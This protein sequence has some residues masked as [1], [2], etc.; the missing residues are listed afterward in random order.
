MKKKLTRS[1]EKAVV[2]GVLAGLAE[3]FD[4]DPV[5][6]RVLAI[7]FLILTGF[8]PGVLLYIAAW[9]IIP[10]AGRRQVDYEVTE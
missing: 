5:L 1:Q 7:A 10:R 2:S 9:I 8:F 3:Y 6:Y 4:H